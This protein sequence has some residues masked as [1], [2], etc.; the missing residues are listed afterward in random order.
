M[1][2]VC[3]FPMYALSCENLFTSLSLFPRPY[4]IWDAD[5]HY[6]LSFVVDVW[7][8]MQLCIFVFTVQCYVISVVAVLSYL[9]LLFHNFKSNCTRLMVV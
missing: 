1:T 6:A 3:W 5:L 4:I 8:I 7:C 9:Y 2:A